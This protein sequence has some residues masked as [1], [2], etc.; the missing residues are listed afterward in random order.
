[1]RLMVGQMMSAACCLMSGGS[2]KHTLLPEPVASTT[3]A[4]LPARASVAACGA[5]RICADARQGVLRPVRGA[6]T[7]RSALLSALSAC[8]RREGVWLDIRLSGRSLLKVL[9]TLKQA[10]VH[11]LVRPWARINTTAAHVYIKCTALMHCALARASCSTAV[12]RHRSK[13]ANRAA[14]SSCT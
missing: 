1:M 6:A 5:A 8:Q 9:C 3:M 13:L 2:W 12:D 11:I 7:W 10:G 4:S 14:I